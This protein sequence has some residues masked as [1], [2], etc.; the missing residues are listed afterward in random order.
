[1][2]TNEVLKKHLDKKKASQTGYSLRVLARQLDLSPSFLSRVFSGQKPVPYA[3]LLK[4][5]KALDIPYEDLTHLKSS[6]SVKM[7][8]G[9][10]PKKGRAQVNTALESWQLTQ[11]DGFNAL[12]QWFYLPILSFTTLANFDGTKEMIARRLGLSSLT[13]EVAVRE[14]ISSGLLIEEEGR[15]VATSNKRR[16]S[17]SKSLKEIRRFHDQMLEKAQTELRTATKEE[18]FSKRLITGI[19]LTASPEKIEAAK[20]KLAECLH[21]IANE[22]LDDEGTEVY[23]LACQLFPLTHGS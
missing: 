14:L 17:D 9:S 7:E 5:G 15:L 20:A 21:D 12:K 3:L 8:E 2:Q 23:Q 1:M 19:T 6:H 10:V 4:L 22:L 18:E 13:V 16:W 11:K